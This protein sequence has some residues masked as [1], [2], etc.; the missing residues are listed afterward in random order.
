M[1]G[2]VCEKCGATPPGYQLWDYCAVCS[3]D[4]CPACIKAGC[5]GHTPALSGSEA[6]TDPFMEVEE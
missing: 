5:C 3:K 6:D 4:L 2:T 1:P